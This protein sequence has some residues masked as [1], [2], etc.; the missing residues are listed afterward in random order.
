MVDV[1]FLWHDHC[2]PGHVADGWFLVPPLRC[3]IH[4]TSVSSAHAFTPEAVALGVIR[5]E[6]PPL[7]PLIIF[8]LPLLV[9]SHL[10][11]CTGVAIET[12]VSEI[13]ADIII[14]DNAVNIKM[15]SSIGWSLVVQSWPVAYYE[16]SL[17]TRIEANIESQD[18][19]CL[20][21][22]KTFALC[23]LHAA[24]PRCLSTFF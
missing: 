24:A 8:V 20:L 21:H 6:P 17:L 3:W 2:W 12:T 5:W 1:W 23:Y 22:K 18:V 7:E 10:R 9:L 15:S 13:G 16:I 11:S 4:Y 14:A 19:G